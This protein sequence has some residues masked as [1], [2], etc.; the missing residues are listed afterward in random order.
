M[1]EHYFLITKWQALGV[2]IEIMQ[3]E[4]P[5]DPRL[6]PDWAP[7]R[8]RDH[9]PLGIEG[10]LSVDVSVP[11]LEKAR[12]I[13]R[14]HFDWPLLSERDLPGEHSRGAAFL[15]GDAVIEALCPT[16]DDTALAA[17][18]RNTPGLCGMTFKV[19]D[20]AAAAEHLRERG[21]TLIGDVTTRF[22]ITPEQ[23]HGRLIWLT[24]HIPAGWPAPQCLIR[25]PARFPPVPDDAT[26]RMD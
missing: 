9:H 19:R 1:E 10:L 13:F 6:Q 23:A 7:M 21:F 15:M 24:E 12:E 11:D 16:R 26:A 17:P 2:R 4:L 5:N 22:A 3:G 8:W 20:A 18:A 14:D 25:E